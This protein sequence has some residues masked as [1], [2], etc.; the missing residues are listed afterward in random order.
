[1]RRI[2]SL[3]LLSFLCLYES[4][5]GQ[6]WASSDENA[7]YAGMSGYDAGAESADYNYYDPAQESA[8]EQNEDYATTNS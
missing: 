5:H 1:M 3:C 6:D 7:D 4:I 8:W 2:L